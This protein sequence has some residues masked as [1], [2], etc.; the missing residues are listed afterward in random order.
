[1]NSIPTVIFLV[2]TYVRL[3]FYVSPPVI[4]S[5]TGET[6]CIRF[7]SSL[8]FC[9]S[10]LCENR[11]FSVTLFKDFSCFIFRFYFPFL[12]LQFVA[13]RNLLYQFDCSFTVDVHQYL[14]ASVKCQK[15]RKSILVEISIGCRPF[16]YILRNKNVIPTDSPGKMLEMPSNE[17][18][19]STTHRP[20]LHRM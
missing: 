3:N 10:V 4:L 1:M 13:V 2:R 6:H 20:T 12:A 7:F 9:I 19:F 17:M 8:K 11:F 16:Y 18:L 15:L 14:D 5:L